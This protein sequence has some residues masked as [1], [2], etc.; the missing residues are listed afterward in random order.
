[1]GATGHERAEAREA[2]LHPTVPRPALGT[3]SPPP[4]VPAVL[5][6]TP[7]R[8]T[9]TEDGQDVVTRGWCISASPSVSS[10][11]VKK[12]LCP[13]TRSEKPPVGYHNITATKDLLLRISL[14]ADYKRSGQ[15]KL[16][17]CQSSDFQTPP[18]Q[19]VHF[20]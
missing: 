7:A 6:M 3:K 2:A 13:G 16:G 8:E 11:R 10:G 5:R 14:L 1:M 12:P 18:R 15:L 19:K 17:E 20:G 9:A 4:Y